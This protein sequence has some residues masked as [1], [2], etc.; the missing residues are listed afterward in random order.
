MHVPGVVVH[1]LKIYGL[2]VMFKR[3]DVQRL[4]VKELCFFSVIKKSTKSKRQ[5]QKKERVNFSNLYLYQIKKG[6]KKK[7]LTR[8]ISRRPG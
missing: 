1:I 4:F 5:T 3:K 7:I 2:Y 6:K 8:H